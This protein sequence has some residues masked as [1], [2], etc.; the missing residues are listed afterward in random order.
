M[1]DVNEKPFSQ[2][3]P[4]ELKHVMQECQVQGQRAFDTDLISDL[5]IQRTRYFLAASYLLDP[6]EFTA[7]SVYLVDGE[8]HPLTVTHTDGIMAHGSLLG[9]SASAAFPLAM[10]T[11]LQA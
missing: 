11:L 7:G 10:L 4:E 9:S 1:G 3:T 6:A 5:Q 8:E 2:M